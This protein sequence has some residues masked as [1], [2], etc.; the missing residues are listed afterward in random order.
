M[1]LKTVALALASACMLGAASSQAVVVSYLDTYDQLGTK[2]G[3]DGLFFVRNAG[4]SAH[5][6]PSV[7]RGWAL[8]AWDTR[9]RGWKMLNKQDLMD[10]GSIDFNELL[11][12]KMYSTDIGPFKTKVNTF[13]EQISQCVLGL[14]EIKADD[15]IIKGQIETLDAKIGSYNGPITNLTDRVV[16]LENGQAVLVASVDELSAGVAALKGRVTFVEGQVTSLSNA[17]VAVDEKI[18]L[19][20]VE[21]KTYTDVAVS[22]LKIDMITNTAKR[23]NAAIETAKTY[24][25]GQIDIEKTR[26]DQSA[27]SK[28]DAKANEIM[29]N[30]NDK[31]GDL[32]GNGNVT[33]FVNVKA[34][35]IIETAATDATAKSNQAKADAVAEA[36]AAVPAIFDEKIVPVKAELE[37]EISAVDAKIVA[38]SNALDSAATVK[39]SSAKAEANGYTD[40]KITDLT[41]DGGTIDIKVNAL[42]NGDVKAAKDAADA[43]DVKAVQAQATASSAETAAGVA[44]DR[45]DE[46]AA[47]AA[48]ADGKAVAAQGSADAN[49]A[50]LA[51]I[52]TTVTAAISTAKT[53]AISASGSNADAKVAAAKTE[54]Q[55]TINSLSTE[56]YS[57][58]AKRD[59]AVSNNVIAIAASIAQE[60]ADMAELNAKFRT[61][62]MKMEAVSEASTDATEKADK[63]KEEA[64]ALSAY[65]WDE[66]GPIAS[67]TIAGITYNNV[68]VLKNKTQ[69]TASSSATAITIQVP[70]KDGVIGVQRACSIYLNYTGTTKPTIAIVGETG[71]TILTGESGS[72]D[73]SD[74]EAGKWLIYVLEVAKNVFWIQTERFNN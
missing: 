34:S 4:S 36:K 61:D 66:T 51:G 46:A 16:T 71:Q 2:M 18:P 56:V 39:A 33:D 64:V 44:Q 43:A 6:D 59:A 17:V 42:K 29:G 22:D 21:A 57:D 52:S 68:Y 1:K 72:Y 9:G 27:Q 19:A 62:A 30:V 24:T 23:V 70:S 74:I 31:L 48:V 41:K 20:M 60:K 67:K 53:E 13:G 8:Y 50:K 7:K 32:G 35:G 47:A 25:D 49:T 45:A 55:D 58:M 54:I 37:G 63:A 10:L 26:A 15:I 12:K 40:T 73:Y 14:A 38:T 65:A 11:T 69:L 3:Q 5:G 28:V